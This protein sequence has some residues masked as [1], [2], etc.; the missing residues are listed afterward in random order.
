MGPWGHW[1]Q[2]DL[3]TYRFRRRWWLHAT[4]LS[5]LLTPTDHPTRP[6]LWPWRQEQEIPIAA[7]TA[8]ELLIRGA[9]HILTT[10]ALPIHPLTATAAT[11]AASPSVCAP[12][13]STTPPILAAGAL[14][15]GKGS[16]GLLL[17]LLLLLG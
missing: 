17:L 14:A 2:W 13:A 8:E 5:C 12:A 9:V 4:T 7:L 6:V 16:L 11:T 10:K 15:L 3:N 1:G